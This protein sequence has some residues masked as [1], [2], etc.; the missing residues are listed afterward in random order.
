MLLN[1]VS[2]S[3]AEDSEVLWGFIRGYVPGAKPADHPILAGLVDRAIA[4]YHDFVKPSKRFRPPTDQERKALEDLKARLQAAGGAGAEE[5]QNI[6]YAV[7]KEHAFE[8]LRAWFSAIYEV[9]LG[10]E[11]GPRF[12]S[13]IALYGVAQTCTLIDRGLK[14]EL[15][16]AAA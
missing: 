6:V 14:G 15:G 10:Q 13:F 5:L 11:Q 12:G 16:A 1:L 3:N 8:P 7:G 9:L 4:Y 2:A